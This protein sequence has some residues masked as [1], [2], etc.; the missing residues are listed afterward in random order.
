MSI[1]PLPK[2]LPLFR[3]KDVL[4][5]LSALSQGQEQRLRDC[6]AMLRFFDQRFDR[7]IKKSTNPDLH[8][9]LLGCS[10]ENEFQH[11][12]LESKPKDSSVSES[13]NEPADPWTRI[14]LT[15]CSLT[16]LEAT[17]SDSFD[18]VL[19]LTL[20]CVQELV[21]MIEYEAAFD[22]LK[23]CI[24]A[25][26]SSSFYSDQEQR[27]G[28]QKSTVSQAAGFLSM[29]TLCE[30]GIETLQ[31]EIAIAEVATFLGVTRKLLEQKLNGNDSIRFTFDLFGNANPDELAQFL[32]WFSNC[33]LQCNQAD[34]AN[35]LLLA[36]VGLYPSDFNA[37]HRID[38]L[39]GMVV[40]GNGEDPTL[41][42]A[43]T[44]VIGNAIQANW[45]YAAK[46]LGIR[47]SMFPGV[48]GNPLKKFL[49]LGLAIKAEFTW[50]SQSCFELSSLTDDRRIDY[51]HS[52]SSTFLAAGRPSLALEVGAG[53]FHREGHDATVPEEFKNADEA[54]LHCYAFKT[55]FP[56]DRYKQLQF[57]T[58]FN[59]ILQ[60]V[61][62][63]QRARRHLLCIL[64]LL[65]FDGRR[66]TRDQLRR[67]LEDVVTS[68]PTLSLAIAEQLRLAFEASHLR[69]SA[70][71]VVEELNCLLSEASIDG[72]PRFEF[73]RSRLK[74]RLALM[75]GDT[76]GCIQI[77]E[78]HLVLHAEDVPIS[79][80]SDVC[81]RV[82]VLHPMAANHLDLLQLAYRKCNRSQDAARTQLNVLRHF[83]D[84]PVTSKL[85][86]QWSALEQSSFAKMLAEID[87][88][89]HKS[90]DTW[91]ASPRA[92][93]TCRW[94]SNMASALIEEGAFG[95]ASGVLQML[96][97]RNADISDSSPGVRAAQF[98]VVTLATAEENSIIPLL[99]FSQLFA[100]VAERVGL[101]D[102]GALMLES[103]TNASQSVRNFPETWWLR[104][105][106][107]PERIEHLITWI[108]MASVSDPDRLRICDAVVNEIGELAETDIHGYSNRVSFWRQ[109]QR[110]RNAV[111]T[112]GLEALKEM[113][114][115]S[116]SNQAELCKRISEW[117]EQLDNR[118]IVEQV[119][120]LDAIN[121]RSTSGEPRAPT[122]TSSSIWATSGAWKNILNT[123]ER[124][125]ENWLD[126]LRS[127]SVGTLQEVSVSADSV[128]THAASDELAT[129]QFLQRIE[130]FYV[131]VD[132]EVTRRYEHLLST[133]SRPPDLN[134]LIKDGQTWIRATFDTSGRLFWWA[135]QRSIDAQQ[136]RFLG[137]HC[138]TPEAYS[139][140]SLAN[141]EADACIEAVWCVV[142]NSGRPELVCAT[143]SDWQRINERVANVATLAEGIRSPI[144]EPGDVRV[145]KR[146]HP[147]ILALLREIELEIRVPQTASCRLKR[148]QTAWERCYRCLLGKPVEQSLMKWKDSCL[149]EICGKKLAISRYFFDLS[150][151]EIQTEASS[152]TALTFTVEGPLLSVPVSWLTYAGYPIF[153]QVKSTS[154]ALSLTL[155]AHKSKKERAHSRLGS[156]LCGVWEQP[157]A[158]NSHGF[159]MLWRGVSAWA[160]KSKRR[161][162]LGICDD[163]LLTPENF[164]S[165]TNSGRFDVIV[166]GGHG[167]EAESG[168]EF[169]GGENTPPIVWR[170]EG[171][172][173]GCEVLVL[174]SCSVGRLKQASLTDVK[175]L[176]TRIL[177]SGGKSIVAAQWDVDDCYGAVFLLEF[178]A[179]CSSDLMQGQ[180]MAAA[181]NIARKKA[182]HRYS[183]QTLS[184]QTEL[185]CHHA[186]SAFEFYGPM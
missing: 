2:I 96:Q 41:V 71:L 155:H 93:Q 107:A 86:L 177:L 57:V 43:G 132:D 6:L 35:R 97:H 180:G 137:F 185:N 89:R 182:W 102:N 112:S 46:K 135:F 90:G 23:E 45:V 72:S 60:G 178:L 169:C 158:R 176:Y 59:S 101:T 18:R 83:A 3:Q 95:D 68:A 7:L 22:L 183:S 165:A 85:S 164:V 172:F 51:C 29:S 145:L 99:R 39:P 153:A 126:Q 66:L 4:L 76:Q 31:P 151:L 175:G 163:P 121:E 9:Y 79:T 156:V 26:R 148:L 91:T 94:I 11:A 118:L 131:D 34:L 12:L 87:R 111:L 127:Y 92:P 108:S 149:N 65:D 133:I 116:K 154:V 103:F 36:S 171:S 174:L 134:D 75:N 84:V 146:Q 1:E 64:G 128:S 104:E 168:I 13:A 125:F 33:L 52:I 14:V 56:D 48:R 55:L 143:D 138:S 50:R 5:Q 181:F 54:E 147:R 170:G 81:P 123:D 144:L 42:Q 142:R 25:C 88:H 82:S 69:G 124:T 167:V 20:E 37:L 120:L 70:K 73:D 162:F 114:H 113:E 98:P 19:S 179:E 62:G 140:I 30:L 130:D 161:L 150:A 110:L 61:H 10:D 15:A 49:A 117:L 32:I 173:H 184:S 8:V 58:F 47:G 119:I 78:R 40:S 106:Q 77:L 152:E 186:I 109:L 44:A 17:A 21:R 100:F 157:N 136:A 105:L 28:L 141:I 67:S 24:R 129:E 38:A 53:A 16:S 27:E 122:A 159:P 80:A 74:A 160:E 115:D 139:A 166:L 63:H